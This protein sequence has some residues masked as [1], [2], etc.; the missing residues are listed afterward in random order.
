MTWKSL[1]LFVNTLIVHDEYSLLS[2]DNLMQPNQMHLSKK[3]IT[4]WQFFY[5][6]FK[7]AS[8]FEHSQ[9][10]MTLL[11]YVF[12]KLRTPKYVVR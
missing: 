1:T 10:R 11:A 6:F 12:M 9:K 4:L 2:R 7:S 5:A 3:Q 8:S